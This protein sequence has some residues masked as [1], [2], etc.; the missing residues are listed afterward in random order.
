M[1]FTAALT[2]TN[3]EHRASDPSTPLYTRWL[4]N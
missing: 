4:R 3:R 2:V 1:S